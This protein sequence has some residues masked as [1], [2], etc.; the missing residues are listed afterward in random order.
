WNIAPY[1]LGIN[2]DCWWRRAKKIKLGE[3]SAL[4][5]SPEDMILNLCVSLYHD[6]FERA[7]LRGLC[8][9]FHT[10]RY[11]S[12]ETDWNLFEEIVRKSSIARPVN[13]LLHLVLKYFY[14][15]KQP[16]F[17]HIPLRADVKFTAM[18]EQT[19]FNPYRY[20]HPFFTR[21]LSAGTR[22]ERMEIFFSGLFPSRAKMADTYSTRPG[23]FN[24]YIYYAY[25][26]IELA[27]KYGKSCLRLLRLRWA[28]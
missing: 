24:L 28:G 22:R 6:N 23:S 18:V 26:P 5:P 14:D 20:S 3:A 1:S 10:I 2:V 17:M 27:L 11:Y 8:D 25:R 19:F 16:D 15:G 12:E 9:I 13:S 4:I 21:I 7:A